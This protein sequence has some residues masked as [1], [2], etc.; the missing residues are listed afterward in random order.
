MVLTAAAQA[1]SQCR[2]SHNSSPAPPFPRPVPPPNQDVKFGAANLPAMNFIG[3]GAKTPQAWLEFLGEVKDKRVPPI[4]SPFQINFNPNASEAEPGPPQGIAPAKEALPS[5]GDASLTCSCADCPVAPGCALVGGAPGAARR[6]AGGRAAAARLLRLEPGPGGTCLK[7]TWAP[8]SAAGG[9][10][11]P[12]H[13]AF[14]LAAPHRPPSLLPFPPSAPPRPAP[15]AAALGPAGRAPRLPRGRCDVLGPH[16]NPFIHRPRPRR[17]R[18]GRVPQTRQ[19]HAGHRVDP[20]WCATG[21]DALGGSGSGGGR[22]A[23][24]CLGSQALLSQ[25]PCAVAKAQSSV[26]S[27]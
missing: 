9:A 10:A 16:A 8:P 18:R 15:P 5:C 6:G 25:H 21:G 12:E 2:A 22:G 13:D 19:G 14:R 11:L 17:G 7:Q 20:L 24:L 4:G 1:A 26:G 3:G 23:C 27:V